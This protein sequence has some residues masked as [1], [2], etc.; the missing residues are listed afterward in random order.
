MLVKFSTLGG[1]VFIEQRNEYDY[2]PMTRCFRFGEKGNA[3]FAYYGVLV[4]NDPA[5]RWYGH[6]FKES[7]FLFA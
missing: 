3:E 1:G 4:S 6:V 7:D 5:P 2:T